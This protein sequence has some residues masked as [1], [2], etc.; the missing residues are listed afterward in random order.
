MPR[1]FF[2]LIA[3]LLLVACETVIG[4]DDR[5]RIADVQAEYDREFRAAIAADGLTAQPG[6]FEGTLA[7]ISAGASGQSAALTA[8]YTLLEGM[9]HLQTNALGQAR[10]IAPEVEAAAPTLNTDGVPRRNT[11]LA[12]NYRSMLRGREAV[13]ALRSLTRNSAEDHAQ[14]VEIVS[15][16]EAETAAVTRRLCRKDAVD[17]GASVVAAYQAAA[18]VEADRALALACIPRITDPAACE[19]F[20]ERRAQLQDARSLLAR[21]IGD[22]TET[23]QVAGIRRQIDRDLSQS[24]D[25]GPPPLPIDPCD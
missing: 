22:I 2:A 25:G 20:L 13:A 6:R 8:F 9:I 7:M 3:T 14:R 19:G 5:I 21:F 15:D 4:S 24:L 17:D 1:P 23:S 16:I 11:V 12:E 10:A 18:L